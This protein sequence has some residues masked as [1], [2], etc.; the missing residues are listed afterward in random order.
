MYTYTWMYMC[1]NSK[2]GTQEGM[3]SGNFWGV[4]LLT[5]FGIERIGERHLLITLY[6]VLFEF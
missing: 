2:K 5:I 4:E 1:K 3:N 6:P